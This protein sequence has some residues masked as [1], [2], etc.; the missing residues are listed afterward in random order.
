MIKRVDHDMNYNKNHVFNTSPVVFTDLI[1]YPFTICHIGSSSFS[2]GLNSVLL[3]Y[4]RHT[5]QPYFPHTS[6]SPTPHLQ[7]PQHVSLHS[8][9]TISYSHLR[10]TTVSHSFPHHIHPTYSLSHSDPKPHILPDPNKKK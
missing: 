5:I 8:T 2:T 9:A 6:L 1:S 7:H 10:H 4:L 3:P